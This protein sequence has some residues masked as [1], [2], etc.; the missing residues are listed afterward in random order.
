MH[1]LCVRFVD[2]MREICVKLFGFYPDLNQN[3][4]GVEKRPFFTTRFALF[5]PTVFHA[6][7]AIFRS[8]IGQFLPII[9]RTN[10]NDNYI[11]LTFNYW[12]I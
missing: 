7:K 4:S 5:L 8:V 2:E 9:N 3:I 11:K 1:K 12:R 10:N 6:R